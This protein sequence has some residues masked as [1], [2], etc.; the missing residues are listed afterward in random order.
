MDKY[1]DHASNLVSLRRIE[2]QIR[3]IQKM[4]EGRKY[5]VDILIQ[6]RAVMRAIARVEENILEKHFAG[7][8]TEAV[9]GSSVKEKE[10]KLKEIMKLIHQFRAV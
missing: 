2:G 7:C 3:G 9:M 4:I 10:N 1:P 6:V 5:C 8:V